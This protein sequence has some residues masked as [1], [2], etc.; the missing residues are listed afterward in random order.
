MPCE[1]DIFDG[2]WWAPKWSDLPSP[3]LP[4]DPQPQDASTLQAFDDDLEM[5][6]KVP[7]PKRTV[8]L[9]FAVQSRQYP[10][11]D[12]NTYPLQLWQTS[13][14]AAGMEDSCNVSQPIY[15]FR[16][17]RYYDLSCIT[18]RL[19]Y[20]QAQLEAKPDGCYEY[21]KLLTKLL[22]DQGTMFNPAK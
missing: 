11:F 13:K 15:N 2:Q 21:G 10:E 20:L 8:R 4:P 1:D 18:H 22:Q 6:M 19:H 7:C 9:D 5:G 16:S 17:L 12:L 3:P 14:F